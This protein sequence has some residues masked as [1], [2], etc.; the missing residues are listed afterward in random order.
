MV[1]DTPTMLDH[2]GLVVE[3]EAMFREMGFEEYGSDWEAD[4]MIEWWEEVITSDDYEVVVARDKMRIVGVSVAQYHSYHPWHN[5]P[6]RAIESAHHAVPDLPTYR[7]SKIMIQLL[8]AML[9][10]LAERGARYFF[11]G[12][13][14]KPQFKQWGDYLRRRGFIDSAHVLMTKL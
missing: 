14:P 10:K 4:K 9:V 11:I 7:R 8:D 12:Y 13:D 1:I 5:G 6:L 3:S 2:A